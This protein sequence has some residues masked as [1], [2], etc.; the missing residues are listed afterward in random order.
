ML[1]EEFAELAALDEAAYLE[2]LLAQK[3]GLEGYGAAITK[4]R[5]TALRASA[6]CPAEVHCR[7]LL[8][9]C[10][11]L[12]GALA[13]KASALAAGVGNLVASELRA[14][15]EEISGKYET[16][17][18]R[19]QTTSANAEEVKETHAYTPHA[20]PTHRAMRCT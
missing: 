18:S 14:I 10:D 20:Y 11:E 1:C 13:E 16:I 4:W 9:Q 2:A 3:L 6:A 17:H 7:L 12:K 8:V 19:L 5:S 15:S